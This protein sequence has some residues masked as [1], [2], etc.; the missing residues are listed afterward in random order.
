M[1]QVEIGPKKEIEIVG[2]SLYCACA[3]T[4]GWRWK[5]RDIEQ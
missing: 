4:I 3:T 1:T 5:E 2:R